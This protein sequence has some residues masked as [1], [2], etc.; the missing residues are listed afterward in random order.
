MEE[1]E[2]STLYVATNNTMSSQQQGPAQFSFGRTTVV[3]LRSCCA[4]LVA[5]MKPANLWDRNDGPD[6]QRVHGTRFWRVLGQREM[7]P[8]FVIVRQE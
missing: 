3:V 7:R 5:V 1:Q 6:S 8:G 2:S 4:P